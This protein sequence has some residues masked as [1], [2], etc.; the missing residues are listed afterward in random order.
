MGI[1]FDNYE[2]YFLDHMEG[3]LSP[4]MERELDIF[5]LA[6]PDLKQDLDDFDAVTIPPDESIIYPTKDSLKKNILSSAYTDDI[7]LEE[8]MVS[9]I[10]G[11]LNEEDEAGLQEYLHSHPA[12]SR[13]M[14]AFRRTRI[15]VDLS[16]TYRDKSKLRRKAE[17]IF[18][19]RVAWGIAAAAAVII[20]L[21]SVR[22]FNRIEESPAPVQ[23][24]AIAEIISAPAIE[25]QKELPE[26]QGKTPA[27]VQSK[28]I[29]NN[30][31][32]QRIPS[33]R[34]DEIQE[35]PSFLASKKYTIHRL[36]K[37]PVEKIRTIEV[38][39]PSLFAHLTDKIMHKAGRE[40]RDN[41]PL[42]ELRKPKLNFWAVLSSGIKGYNKITD[43]EIELFVYKNNEGKVSSYALIEHDRL[44]LNKEFNLE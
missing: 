21:L 5:L 29:A 26:T 16:I 12:K 41:T 17:L 36:K 44:I 28:E 22:Y 15:P 27:I 7:R 30:D 24:K 4:E 6:N 34:M 19:P 18:I 33:F 40:I 32:Q 9:S 35:T 43:R 11:L 38:K 3:R 23:E 25:P 10:E 31:Q 2:Q 20:I 13:E 8:M 14:E 39:E 42:E 37:R 1:N